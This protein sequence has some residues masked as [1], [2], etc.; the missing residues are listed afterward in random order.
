MD[1][2]EVNLRTRLRGLVLQF[3]DEKLRGCILRV[4]KEKDVESILL[5][6]MIGVSYSHLY[7]KI[8]RV[9]TVLEYRRQSHTHRPANCR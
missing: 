6:G 2:D 7:N 3:L 8:Y 1:T 9:L 5:K 4:V